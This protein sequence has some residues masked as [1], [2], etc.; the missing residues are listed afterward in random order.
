MSTTDPVREYLQEKGC[1]RKVIEGGLPDL[2]ESW[3]SICAS[4]IKG[5]RLGLDDYLNDMDVRQLLAESLGVATTQQREAVSHRLQEADDAV[6]AALESAGKCLW[7]DE[8]AEEEGWS[9]RKNWWY[10]S[11]PKKAAAELLAE[12]ESI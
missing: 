10:F 5:Y 3:E 1:S 6:K 2:I 4:V 9:A 11:K 12:I 7:G 8:V